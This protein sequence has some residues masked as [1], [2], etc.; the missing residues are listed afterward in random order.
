MIS[1]GADP[2]FAPV[3]QPMHSML[4]TEALNYQYAASN[5][6]LVDTAQVDH[7]MATMSYGPP[8]F[9]AGSEQYSNEFSNGGDGFSQ[10]A[11]SHFGNIGPSAVESNGVHP[12]S[13]N[14]GRLDIERR[15]R[16]FVVEGVPMNL[17]HLT[18]ASFFSVSLLRS[19]YSNT[20]PSLQRMR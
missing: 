5:G 17:S 3:G 6:T 19:Q 2:F 12:F 13:T 4:S 1:S 7:P 11:F 20:L 15:S 8:F 18:L 9:T 16:A 14:H 10:N